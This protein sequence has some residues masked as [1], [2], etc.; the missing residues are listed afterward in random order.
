MRVRKSV[1]AR[2]RGAAGEVGPVIELMYS[3]ECECGREVH[4]SFEMDIGKTPSP[5]KRVRCVSCRTIVRTH[6]EGN[7]MEV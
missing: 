6:P 4:R 5:M 2:G 3:A 1:R 7:A